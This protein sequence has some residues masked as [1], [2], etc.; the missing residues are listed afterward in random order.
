MLVKGWFYVYTSKE[1]HKSEIT[2]FMQNLI[3]VMKLAEMTLRQNV[4]FLQ[5]N[6]Q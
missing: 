1:S 2:S 5:N 6:S 4:F 3:Y